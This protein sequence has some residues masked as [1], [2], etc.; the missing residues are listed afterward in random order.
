MSTSQAN[1]F[2]NLLK[3]VVVDGAQLRYY[4]LTQLNDPRYGTFD[5]F[6]SLL[7]SKVC[8]FI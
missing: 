3:T 1:P 5:I 2:D 8:L 6:M 7:S 4:D